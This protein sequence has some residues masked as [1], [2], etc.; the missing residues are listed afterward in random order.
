MELCHVVW[1]MGHG[2]KIAERALVEPPSGHQMGVTV[3][4]FLHF[5]DIFQHALFAFSSIS[6]YVLCIFLYVS[7]TFYGQFFYL[8]YLCLSYCSEPILPS[9]LLFLWSSHITPCETR[10]VT[11]I[12][13][14]N[15]HRRLST[16][17]MTSM[18]PYQSLNFAFIKILLDLNLR[19]LFLTG[20]AESKLLSSL[21][22]ITWRLS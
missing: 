12:R 20:P 19:P 7:L 8:I 4:Y 21:F 15:S 13:A 3:V 5:S 2:E 6:H 22:L 11:N 18:A 16:R 17:R 14:T 10:Q 9:F 1:P